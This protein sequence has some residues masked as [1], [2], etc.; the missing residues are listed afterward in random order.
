MTNLPIATNA[1]ET[2]TCAHDPYFLEICT[3]CHRDIC[4]LCRI[5]YNAED[6]T[7]SQL[8]MTTYQCKRCTIQK[9][10]QV[11]FDAISNATK[12]IKSM[13]TF[14]INVI[15]IIA[16]YSVGMIVR[17]CNNKRQC[18][19]EISLSNRFDLENTSSSMDSDHHK[20]L[21]IP[22]DEN[23]NTEEKYH[24]VSIYGQKRKIFCK[25]CTRKTS[26][27]H[28]TPFM[29]MMSTKRF[30]KNHIGIYELS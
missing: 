17:C 10:Y 1:Q 14:E 15:N 23:A 11:M 22:Y 3:F 7:S 6:T 9:E 20:I 21:N 4:S 16:S 28:A 30:R 8:Q 26:K 19:N 24:Y 2:T 27:I 5:A 13:H 25:V 12:S 29:M 18:H